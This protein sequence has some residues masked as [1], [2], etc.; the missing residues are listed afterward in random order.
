MIRYFYYSAGTNKNSENVI[1]HGFPN[2]RA[3]IK[4]NKTVKSG[5]EQIEGEAICISC[6]TF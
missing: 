5:H 4:T 3:F 1:S 2:K 6:H